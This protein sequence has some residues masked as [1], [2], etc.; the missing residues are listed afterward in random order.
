MSESVCTTSS[1][2]L[3]QMRNPGL[4]VGRQRPSTFGS[5]ALKMRMVRGI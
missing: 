1:T 4:E 5:A 3:R 2:G